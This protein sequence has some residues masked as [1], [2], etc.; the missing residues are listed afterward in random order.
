MIELVR[1]EVLPE[2]EDYRILGFDNPPP[3][4]LY[5]QISP[6]PCVFPI[7]PLYNRFYIVSNPVTSPRRKYTQMALNA[8]RCPPSPLPNDQLALIAQG[9]IIARSHI[10]RITTEIDCL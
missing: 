6:N 5:I 10:A 8:A 7:F 1:W 3:P 4:M 9:L 2:G